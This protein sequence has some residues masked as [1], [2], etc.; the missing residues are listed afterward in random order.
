MSSQGNT[1]V[2]TGAASGIG[3][4][5]ART[6]AGVG[7]NL[8]LADVLPMDTVLSEVRG[9]GAEAAGVTTDVTQ[10]RAVAALFDAGFRRFGRI[11]TLVNN[12]GIVTH[13][14]VGA[15]RWPKLRDMPEEQFQ[16][17]IGTNLGGTFLCAKHAIPYMESLNAG[18]I[19]NFGQGN[20][21]RSERR[22]NI[23]TAVYS[24]SKIASV[25]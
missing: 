2:I 18:H 13:F 24:T 11:D 12:A 21:K 1:V 17:V 6:F 10:E 23:G 20:L 16:R 7:A 3:R 15:P 25:R 9:L 4:F 19:V 5:V 14:H 8:V 22:P